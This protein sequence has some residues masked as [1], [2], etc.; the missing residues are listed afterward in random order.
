[1]R[2]LIYILLVFLLFGCNTTKYYKEDIEARKLESVVT[3]DQL[4]FKMTTP[5]MI[6]WTMEQEIRYVADTSPEDEYRS[7]DQTWDLRYGDCEDFAIFNAYFLKRLSYDYY[8][9]NISAPKYVHAICVWRTPQGYRYSS[10]GKLNSAVCPS[11]EYIATR[12][13]PKWYVVNIYKLEDIEYNNVKL[14]HYEW[15]IR[16]VE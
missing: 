16:E 2:Y 9:L 14:K 11:L 12:I 8:L 6:C 1:M 4:Q 3:F 7:P 10:N 13:H 5:E 15:M